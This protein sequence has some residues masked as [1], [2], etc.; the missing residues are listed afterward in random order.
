VNFFSKVVSMD[1]KD[2]ILQHKMIAMNVMMILNYII[3]N[4]EK[5]QGIIIN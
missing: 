3:K 5:E 2:A 1:A 4:A